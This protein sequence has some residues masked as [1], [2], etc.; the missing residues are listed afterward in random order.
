MPVTP[1]ACRDCFQASNSVRQNGQRAMRCCQPIWAS[2]W[3][4]TLPLITPSKSSCVTWISATAPPSAFASRVYD[5][6]RRHTPRKTRKEGASPYLII[7]RSASF[8]PRD[9]VRGRGRLQAVSR[10]DLPQVLPAHLLGGVH[11][12]A[13]SCPEPARRTPQQKLLEILSQTVLSAVAQPRQ[14]ERRA[15][16]R[17]RQPVRE[18]TLEK[19]LAHPSRRHPLP[20]YCRKEEPSPVIGCGHS[21]PVGRKSSKGT[22]G[23]TEGR[24]QVSLGGVS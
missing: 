11:L 4:G 21:G 5:T 20:L 19:P 17:E 22:T 8:S 1:D 9:R 12:P 13:G 14:E 24:R 10:P 23:E 3:L 6:L 18:T 15:R 7:P 2:T 16:R